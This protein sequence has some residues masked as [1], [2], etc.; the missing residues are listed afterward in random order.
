MGLFE[1]WMKAF[2][3]L[4]FDLPYSNYRNGMKAH[5][6]LKKEITK[7]FEAQ[8]QIRAANGSE[9]TS[10]GSIVVDMMLMIQQDLIEKGE[11]IHLDDE[12]LMDTLLVFLMAG[13]ETG[14]RF[15]PTEK[16]KYFNFLTLIIVISGIV[17][18]MR[19]L[20]EH[21]DIQ[22]KLNEEVKRLSPDG[23][24]LTFKQVSCWKF[25]ALVLI[26]SLKGAVYELSDSGS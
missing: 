12:E 19:Y 26:S 3:S 5:R 20:G 16:R 1:T 14:I 9:P 21:T 10:S 18:I 2:C 13:H 22:E 7:L 11:G 8:R 6:E 25:K 15:K 24:E 4:P 23:E 17:S